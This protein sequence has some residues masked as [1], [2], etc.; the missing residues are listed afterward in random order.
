MDQ[1]MNSTYVIVSSAYFHYWECWNWSHLHTDL[2]WRWAI[3]SLFQS[4]ILSQLGCS[5]FGEVSPMG[6]ICYLLW[7]YRIG[8][9]RLRSCSFSFLFI[10]LILE[11]LELQAIAPL[12]LGFV[13]HLNGPTFHQHYFRFGSNHLPL[14]SSSTNT[15]HWRDSSWFDIPFAD[16]LCLMIFVWFLD[17]HFALDGELYVDFA[18]G[19]RRFEN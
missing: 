11:H 12:V 7:T 1:L 4:S 17:L 15:G 10:A 3:S 5:D 9:E 13:W 19:H 18:E 8:Q 2:P 14:F 16:L 6:L